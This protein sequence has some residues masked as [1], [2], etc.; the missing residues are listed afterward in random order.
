MFNVFY[1]KRNGKE[2]KSKTNG[3]T[4]SSTMVNDS[5]GPLGFCVRLICLL[6]NIFICFYIIFIRFPRPA[7]SFHVAPPRSPFP[8]LPTPPTSNFFSVALFYT[9]QY[10]IIL[11][12]FLFSISITPHTKI[13]H[14]INKYHTTLESSSTD[15]CGKAKE[16]IFI[17]LT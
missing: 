8:T 3:T 2:A 11:L 4:F 15:V 16:I 14:A 17:P 5:L 13:S 9:Q 6:I 12:C 10:S 1:S 7:T